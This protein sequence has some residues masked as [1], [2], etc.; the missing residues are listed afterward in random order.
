[1]AKN[2]LKEEGAGYGGLSNDS[3]RYPGPNPQNL[4]MNVAL[5]SQ[6]DHGDV[7]KDLEVRRLSLIIQ[8]GSKY[9][10]KCPLKREARLELTTE[11]VEGNVT[12]EAGCSIPG[13]EDRRGGVS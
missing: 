12:T 11:K 3:Q 9:N 10:H 2:K 7:I 1:M 8:L 5:Y 6:R 4:G 13:L